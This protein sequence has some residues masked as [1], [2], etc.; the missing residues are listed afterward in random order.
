MTRKIF[1]IDDSKTSLLLFESIFEDTDIEVQSETDSKAALKT[2]SEIKPDLIVMDIMMPEIDGFQLLKTLKE[3][4]VQK[5]I[6][7][8]I[9][10]AIHDKRTIR[11]AIDNGAVAYIKKPM[12]VN[13]VIKVINQL[14]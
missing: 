6:P 10:S 13:E 3:D 7:V 5:D 2:I 4:T 8:V 9:I 12:N 1:I 14:L 11:Q